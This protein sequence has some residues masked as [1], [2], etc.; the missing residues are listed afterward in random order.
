MSRISTLSPNALRAMLSPEADDT[1][2]TLLTF[3]GVGSET[4]RIADGYTQS[5]DSDELIYGVVSRGQQYVFIPVEI[6][7]PS[8]ER[9]SV[10]RCQIVI[11]DVTRSLMPTLRSLN[12][13][14]NVNI[15]LVLGSAPDNVEIAFPGFYLGAIGYS[16]EA[17]TGELTLESMANE[18]FPADSFTPS[19]FPGLF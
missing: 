1:L 6:T 17:I 18:P 14:L 16:A 7:L 4:V 3:S 8:E 13:A 9:E 19:G 12:Q 5:L 2:I 10:P 11:H 15:E